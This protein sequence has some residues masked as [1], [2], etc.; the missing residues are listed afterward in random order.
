MKKINVAEIL[1][2]CP[3][4]ME[5]NCTMYD[6]LYFNQIHDDDGCLYKI[7]CY[8]IVDGIRTT[9]NFTDFG[10]FNMHANSKCVIFP[11]GK[12]TWEGFVPPN[13][14]RDG[15]IIFTLC[16]SGNTWISIF[17]K[18]ENGEVR[19]Y[20][21]YYSD[22][23]GDHL[24]HCCVRSNYGSCLLCTE[25]DIDTQRLATEEE[26][27]KLFQAIKDEGYKWDV[28]NK[29]L[30]KLIKPKFKVGDKIKQIGSDRHYIIKTIE[31][32]RYILHNNQF[33]RFTDE[34]IYELV[35]NKFD[36][37][38]LVPFESR[39]L[40]RSYTDC[41]WRPAIFGFYMED[42]PIPYCALGG[43]YW[44]YCIPYEGNEHLRGKVDDCDSF[45]KNWE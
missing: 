19:T 45:Y 4:D 42:K 29:A 24:D 1:R 14:F 40:V 18:N 22:P 5:L 17:K 44:K 23:N 41:L 28:E 15:D 30:V 20:A 12:M 33:L 36:I 2:N 9:V 6:N 16:E 32:D 31:F 8:T 27:E 21:D 11:K 38:S 25:K 26:K 3:R 43:T 7:S 10:T 39:V 35:P 13:N 37:N 34:H